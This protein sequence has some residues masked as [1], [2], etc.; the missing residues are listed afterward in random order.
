MGNYAVFAPLSGD[1]I[2]PSAFSSLLIA[3][4]DGV[5]KRSSLAEYWLGDEQ[6]P[7]KH[8]ALLFSI[9]ASINQFRD[10]GHRQPIGC[11]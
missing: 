9:L 1:G 6:Q 8:T 10:A 4:R 7:V 2:K 11:E 3:N 5:V